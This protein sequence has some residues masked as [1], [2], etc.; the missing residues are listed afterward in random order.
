MSAACVGCGDARRVDHG[1]CGACGERQ[2]AP[3]PAFGAPAEPPR[4]PELKRRARWLMTTGLLLVFVPALLGV[5]GIVP[6]AILIVLGLVLLTAG[7]GVRHGAWWARRW[8]PGP[9]RARAPVQA[10]LARVP[11]CPSCGTPPRP[12]ARACPACG[13]GLWRQPETFGRMLGFAFR[14]V[15]RPNP[16]EPPRGHAFAHEAAPVVKRRYLVLALVLSFLAV[17]LMLT[18]YNAL[19]RWALSLAILLP[20]ILLVLWLRRQDRH[21]P[22]PWTLTAVAVAWGMGVT[23][24]A[25]SLNAVF[26]MGHAWLAGFTEELPKA[27]IVLAFATS[28]ALRPHFN[29][30]LDGLF[31]GACAGVGFAMM[32]NVQYV[33][34]GEAQGTDAAAMA[35]LRLMGVFDHAFYTGITGG[36]LGLLVLRHGH[37]T[38]S[39][40]FAAAA[41]AI[42]LHAA[43]NAS[44]DLSFL[45]L[46]IVLVLASLVLATAYAF[47]KLLHEAIRDEA[48]WARARPAGFPRMPRP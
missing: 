19:A 12:G 4:P 44:T 5:G 46:G 17:Q 9:V 18:S 8:I 35:M 30:P 43:W 48:A 3:P 25:G 14:R 47:L 38:M 27:L 6:A 11:A 29:G 32:E 21:S 41:P 33:F 24:F 1:V 23:L 20:G 39:D 10:F 34:M 31:Y 36:L 22:E 15:L 45:G 42:L 40:Y 28:R 37:V 13:A 2:H 7:F 16:V 26:G